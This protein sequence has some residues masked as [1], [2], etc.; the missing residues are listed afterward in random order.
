[1]LKCILLLTVD[2]SAISKCLNNQKDSTH[3]DSFA[4]NYL[5]PFKKNMFIGMFLVIVKTVLRLSPI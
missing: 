1:M 5:K 3:I 4:K 2:L